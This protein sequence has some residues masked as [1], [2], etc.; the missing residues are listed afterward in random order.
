M[1]YSVMR[2]QSQINITP[3]ID[4]LLVLLIIFMVIQPSS[5]YNLG[6]RVPQ[7]PKHESANP[8]PAIVLSI[9]SDLSL[10]INQ[11]PVALRNLGT[12]LFQILSARADRRMF[13]HATTD[14]PFGTVARIIDIAKGAG[15]GDIGLMTTT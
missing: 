2:A 4:I 3:Y 13:L 11:E 15:A 5:Q 8:P 7:E 14:L 10:R 1:R 12:R 6:A 9:D